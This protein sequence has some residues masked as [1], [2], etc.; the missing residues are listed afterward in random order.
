MGLTGAEFAVGR[1]LFLLFFLPLLLVASACR[2]EEG[3]VQV[4]GFTIEGVESIDK[5]RLEGVLATR[6]SSW[7]PWGTKRYFDRAQFDADLKRIA[8]FYA[9]RGF[10]DARVASF[11]VKLNDDQTK[12]DLTLVVVT[13]VVGY[14]ARELNF[15]FFGWP[16]SVWMG[17][18][19]A[20][21]VYCLIIWYYARYMNKLDIEHNV[22]EED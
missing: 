9:D 8:A 1:L 17:G 7:I 18:Q 5:S 13:F 14:F 11:D 2:E 19:G 20:L 16:F 6:K 15:D 22:H 12:V 3:Q 4:S 21:I 10:P